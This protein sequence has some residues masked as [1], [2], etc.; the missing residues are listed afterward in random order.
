MTGPFRAAR[1]DES[2]PDLVRDRADEGDPDL[3]RDRADESDP[4]LVAAIRAEIEREGPITF[5][6]FM[7]LAL[8][9]PTHGYYMAP[10]ERAGRGGDF[11]TAPEATPLF[12]AC[13]GRQVEEIWE[14][15]GRPSP[16]VLRE[17]GAGSGS[18]ALAVLERLRA[19]R[20]P[21]L[22]A[23]RY[24]PVEMNPHRRDTLRERLRASGLDQFLDEPDGAPASAGHG[25]GVMGAAAPEAQGG[26]TT[27]TG[28]PDE[29]G[30][31]LMG[32]AA[33]EASR[34]AM[35]GAAVP[36]AQSTRAAPAIE[37][38]A[39]PVAG[40]VLANEFVDAL[41]V[42]RVRRV[43][44]VLRELYV[45]WRDGWFAQVPGPPSTPGLASYLERVGVELQDGQESEINLE[46]RPWLAR[47][48]AGLSGGAV[49]IVD[50]GY[51]AADLHSSGRPEGT[52]KGSHEQAVERDPLRRVGRQD[53]T[54]H[55]DLTEL[56]LAAVDAGLEVLGSTTQANFLAGLGFGDLLREMLGRATSVNEYLAARSAAM[57]LLDSRRTGG[58]RVLL[59]G[60]GVPAAP[61][62]RGLSV[63]IERAR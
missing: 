63:R 12:G 59:L 5:D 35:M 19:D 58:F 55:I 36:D 15:L 33:P 52:I 37:P 17:Y 44:G 7:S 2:D 51:E 46:A 38:D 47:A 4:D 20:S 42:H 25:A 1:A 18:L 61:P 39:D 21:L 48:A 49:L 8:Y 30:A 41:P 62:L 56:R 6:R 9:H 60:R 23:L 24:A 45:T 53:L 31:G 54:A 34:A 16:F 27:D 10:A 57:F 50:Y 3:V 28:T 26:G 43:D 11:L 29:H 40:C 22:A 32:A 14:R 13:V